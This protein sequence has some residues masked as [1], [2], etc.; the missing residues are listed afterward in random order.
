MEPSVEALI[1]LIRRF[2]AGEIDA[3]TFDVA[4]REAFL[5]LPLLGEPLFPILDR[6]AIEC[7]EYVDVPALREP[8]DVGD[9]ELAE[10]ARRALREL[11]AL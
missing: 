5:H 1:S 9:A 6:L 11:D 4:Y 10:A 3:Q 7:V 2:V 8:G